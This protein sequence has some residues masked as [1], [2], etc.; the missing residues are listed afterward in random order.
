MSLFNRKRP[1]CYR[2]PYHPGLYDLFDDMASKPHLLIAG[3]TGSGKSVVENGILFNL[4]HDAPDKNQLILIDPKKVELISYKDF[5]HVLY[6]AQDERNA[7]GQNEWLEALQ[8]AER[9]VNARYD[10]MSKKHI[11]MYEGPDVYVVIDELAFLMTSSNKNKY[12]PILKR[13]GMIAR[14]SRVHMLALTQTVKADV[15]PTTLTCN[16][17]SRVALRTSTAQQSRMIVDQAGCERFPD[18]AAEHRALCYFR[19]GANIQKWNVPKYPDSDFT[20]L[21]DWWTSKKCRA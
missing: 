19:D 18:P 9:I 20:A 17:D 1:Q 6:Y 5:P 7:R 15:L 10:E 12:L 14:A 16:F 3:A 8:L 13:L 4:L 11:R 2:T 21:V